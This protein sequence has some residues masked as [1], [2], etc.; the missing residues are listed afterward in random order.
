[1]AL[2][3][4]ILNGNEVEYD[5]TEFELIVFTKYINFGYRDVK[6]LHYSGGGKDIRNPKGNTSCYSM[7]SNYKGSELDLSSFDTSNVTNMHS[8]FSC[9][10]SLKEL[11][12]SNFDTSKVTVMEDMFYCCKSLKELNLSNFDTNKVINMSNMFYKC[13]SLE[14]L[15]L[16]SFNTSK[17]KDMGSMFSYC[18]GLK[19]LDI[20][21]F[22]TSSV[23]NIKSMFYNNKSLGTGDSLKYKLLRQN[24]LNNRNDKV[25]YKTFKKLFNIS[26]S[27]FIN[28]LY[29]LKPTSKMLPSY[30]NNVLVPKIEKFFN[31]GLTIGN[32]QNQLS[33]YD[34]SFVNNVLVNYLGDLYII[35]KNFQG[36]LSSDE[37]K[38]LNYFNIVGGNSSLTV[39]EVK[40]KACKDFD[41]D[42]V[43]KAILKLLS[44]EKLVG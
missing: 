10:K 17:V 39:K 14:E 22:N 44:D 18:E 36:F 15:D 1:M 26:D 21:S 12:L 42:Y 27:D 5:D 23:T 31:D 41:E 33:D 6:F 25:L 3:K 34:S 24:L 29:E 2:V 20:S 19:E 32:I 40:L 38:I 16:S 37:I 28:T 43:N 8:M 13:F 30:E 9:C 35:G 7:F 11:N 4:T